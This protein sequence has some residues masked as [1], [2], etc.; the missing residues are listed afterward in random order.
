MAGVFGG[1]HSGM[2]PEPMPGTLA[3]AMIP[4]L[5]LFLGLD[6]LSGRDL[7]APQNTGKFAQAGLTGGGAMGIF[8]IDV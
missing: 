2:P 6:G 8:G 3:S 1:K 5:G 4:L 7:V